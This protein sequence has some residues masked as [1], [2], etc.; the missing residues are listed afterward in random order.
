MYC[1]LAGKSTGFVTTG[2][3]TGPV[4]G[5]LYGHTVDRD[6]EFRVYPPQTGCTDLAS[7]FLDKAGDI[8]VRWQIVNFILD[9]LQITQIIGYTVN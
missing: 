6:W 3:L 7:Q 9:V 1:F 8:N 5:A 2:K 4:P